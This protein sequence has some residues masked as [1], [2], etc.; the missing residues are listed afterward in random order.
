MLVCGAAAVGRAA[1]GADIVACA[2]QQHDRQ[3]D[4]FG[5]AQH[6][7][8]DTERDAIDANNHL[9]N[10]SLLRSRRDKAVMRGKDAGSCLAGSGRVSLIARCLAIRTSSMAS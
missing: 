8:A 7:A 5:V 1:G 4:H 6:V 9:R 2:L 10:S 3:P